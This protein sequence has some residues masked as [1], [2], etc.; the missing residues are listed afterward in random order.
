MQESVPK[1]KSWSFLLAFK[2]KKDYEGVLKLITKVARNIT[3][4]DFRSNQKDLGVLSVE[5]KNITKILDKIHYKNY[6]I[7]TGSIEAFEDCLQKNISQRLVVTGSLYLIS[8]IHKNY[9]RN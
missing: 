8:E 1:G 4:T 9:G 7:I 6:N 5:I 2:K 3:I